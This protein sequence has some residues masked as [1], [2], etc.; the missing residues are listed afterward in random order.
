MLRFILDNTIL[1]ELPDG[2][3]DLD[4]T[5]RTDRTLLSLRVRVFDAK[6]TFYR[7]GLRYLRQ[8]NAAG[9]CGEVRLTIEED[10]QDAQLWTP[11][12]RGVIKLPAAQWSYEPDLVTVSVEDAGWYAYLNNNKSLEV[13][14]D[15]PLTKNGEPLT[16][17]ALHSYTL[18]NPDPLVPTTVARDLYHLD[19]VLTY[20]VAYLSD[21]RVDFYSQ[22]LFPGGQYEGYAIQTG[23]RLRTTFVDQLDLRPSLSGLLQ[24]LSKNFHLA[25]ALEETGGRPRLRLEPEEYFQGSAVVL[26][27]EEVHPITVQA[28]TQRLYASVKVGSDNTTPAFGFLQFPEGTRWRGF[29]SEQYYLLGQ[30]NV[31][32]ELDLVRSYVVSSNSIENAVF[33]NDDAYDEETFLLQVDR[34]TG[35][36]VQDN[37]LTPTPGAPLYFNPELTNEFVV[38]RWLSGVPASL[39][40]ELGAIISGQFKAFTRVVLTPATVTE[41]S[42][43]NFYPRVMFDDDFSGGGFDNGNVYGNGTAP[44]TSVTQANSRFTAPVAGTYD[45]ST[46]VE[47]AVKV[48][49]GTTINE[50]DYWA[51][52]R[53]RRYDASNTLVD[54]I[55]GPLTY[56][57]FEPYYNIN[58]CSFTN[59]VTINIS[60][61]LA[62][63]GLPM[64]SLD[65]VEVRV[66]IQSDGLYSCPAPFAPVYTIQTSIRPGS[67]FT[68]TGT[69]DFGNFTELVDCGAVPSQLVK[70]R[71]PLR[72]PELQAL[73]DQPT[74]R[75]VVRTQERT[76]TGWL[77]QLKFD[78]GTGLADFTLLTAPN[79][80]P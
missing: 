22:A 1:D 60:L 19:E 46:Q 55:I 64:D 79:L 59:D 7:D 78:H 13:P 27:L 11:L 24:E 28:D 54:E 76:W 21:N 51:N 39:A 45:V 77:E 15:L 9:C 36:A 35:L 12:F 2:W 74:G 30:C 67:F 47:L 63:V 58:A 16:P 4:T 70:F 53:L 3:D 29:A 10:P 57:D 31:D 33:Q 38:R 34:A 6:L 42:P 68:C 62:Q 32:T 66:D 52:L 43:T 26:Q 41:S 14:L 80:L 56:I 75:I 69:P 73:L 20:L 18:L 50:L 72:R 71:A 65:Y 40:A 17:P 5:L 25:L 8:V 49:A 48:L 37:W 23:Y 61:S 44:G